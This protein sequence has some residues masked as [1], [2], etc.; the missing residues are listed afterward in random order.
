[1]EE[2]KTCRPSLLVDRA[3]PNQGVGILLLVES[4]NSHHGWKKVIKTAATAGEKATA[5]WLTGSGSFVSSLVSSRQ[6]GIKDCC[7]NTKGNGA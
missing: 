7:I 1:M 2:K 4:E 5:G 6:G 3:L